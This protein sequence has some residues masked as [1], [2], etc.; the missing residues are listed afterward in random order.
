MHP[1]R[2]WTSWDFQSQRVEE[3]WRHYNRLAENIQTGHGHVTPKS[4]PT[5]IIIHV[6]ASRDHIS[7]LFFLLFPSKRPLLKIVVG[8]YRRFCHT[9]V[10]HCPIASSRTSSREALTPLRPPESRA[11]ATTLVLTLAC[12]FQRT[13]QGFLSQ[14]SFTTLRGTRKKI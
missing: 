2:S 13:L 7:L 4:C 14:P 1:S 3:L 6:G 12:L 11:H 5:L 8:I 10:P 9:H